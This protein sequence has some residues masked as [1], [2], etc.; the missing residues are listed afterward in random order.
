M[1]DLIRHP[2]A[3]ARIERGWTQPELARRVRQAALRRG[4]RSGV[5]RQR[6]WNWEND[7]ATPD[8]D[9]QILLADVFEI[10]QSPV[11]TLGWP[12]WLPSRDSSMSLGPNSTVPA[13]REALRTSMDR[14]T[15]LTYSSAALVGL[16]HQWAATEPQAVAR[17]L[18]GKA[19]DAELVDLLEAA[20]QKLTSLVTEQRQH[21][22]TLLDAH[23]TTVTEL[24][25]GGNYT[26]LVGQRLHT[27][28]ARMSQTVG[29]HRFDQGKHAAAG[30]FW[31]GALHSAHASGDRDLGAGIMSDLAYQATWLNAPQTA[32][33]ILKS[34]VLRTHHPTARSLLHL[35]LARAQAA[36]GEAHACRRSLATAEQELARST[37]EPPAWCSWMSPADLSVDSGQCLLDLGEPE[38]AHKLI[39]EGTALL[40]G[41]RDKTR[42]VFLSYEAG[43]F[44]RAGDIDQAAA[45]AAES[46][47]L[48]KQIGAP[49]CVALVRDLAP[50]FKKHGGVECV[51]DLLER[52]R[53]S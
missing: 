16:A 40:P 19:V 24:I 26:Q 3:Y 48:A 41:A 42:A 9:S 12:Q 8:G 49:R 35:R 1:D 4:L 11:A 25:D 50:E 52:V 18:D 47:A 27:L 32:A 10:D 29:W 45:T 28:A 20:G 43:S 38:R 53:A 21:T 33:E 15:F 17:A 7:R 5:D 39:G 51:D 34:A 46:L 44:L 14:R 37:S 31:H 6:I 22:R 13:L 36:L 30:R 23:L 2:L